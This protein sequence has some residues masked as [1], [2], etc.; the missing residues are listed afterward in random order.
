VRVL[1]FIFEVDVL[2]IAVEGYDRQ[3]CLGVGAGVVVE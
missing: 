2:R 3:S 1:I